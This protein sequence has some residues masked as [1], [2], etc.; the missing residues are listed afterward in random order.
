MKK[1]LIA[2]CLFFLAGYSFSQHEDIFKDGDVLDPDTLQ[3]QFYSQLLG[4]PVAA[5]NNLK[6]YKT[7]YE[8][9][10]TPYR[11]AGKTK[12]GIDCSAFTQKV[13]DDAY[14]INLTG[15]SRTIYSMVDPVSKS[16]LKEGDLLFF[17][18]RRRHISHVGVY[19]GYNKFAHASVSSG[20]VISDLND[21]YYRKYFFAGGRLKTVAN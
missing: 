13:Y 7:V 2:A 12:G 18:I 14:N 20:V 10:G 11:Y 4:I 3:Y 1:I 9:L 21:D 8:W 15:S 17:K 6:L 5:D 19:L 16:E